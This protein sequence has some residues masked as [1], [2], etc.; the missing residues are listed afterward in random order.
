MS[1]KTVGIGTIKIR[2]HDGVLRTSTNVRHVLDLKNLISLGV[3]DSNGCKVT[4]ENGSMR[5][6]KGALV[7]IKAWKV[8]NLYVLSENTILSGAD[9]DSDFTQLW[10]MCMGH[11]SEK[12]LT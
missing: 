7:L 1:C 8:G 11:M 10:H 2:M 12:G 3:L 6:V 5:I 9:P 4:I